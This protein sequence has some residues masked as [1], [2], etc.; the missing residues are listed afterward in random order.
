MRNLWS[1]R[2][3]KDVLN[4][5]RV[6]ETESLVNVMSATN[7]AKKENNPTPKFSN[8]MLK[9]LERENML[10]ALQRVEKK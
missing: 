10:K 7:E 6:Q 1:G 4:S 3:S 2:K 8:L 5:S 9:V